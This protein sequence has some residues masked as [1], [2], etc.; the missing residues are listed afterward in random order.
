M[1][2]ICTDVWAQL[3]KRDNALVLEQYS[4]IKLVGVSGVPL[5]ICGCGNVQV[6][7]KGSLACSCIYNL[8]AI[9]GQ[10][11]EWVKMVELFGVLAAGKVYTFG[12]LA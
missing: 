4:G 12:G 11:I 1:S 10:S 3:V 2:L 9:N 7:L 8:P 5:S 6:L